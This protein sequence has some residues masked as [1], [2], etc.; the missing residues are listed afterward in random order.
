M[1][2]FIAELSSLIDKSEFERSWQSD[3]AVNPNFK[4]D[5][6]FEGRRV[7]IIIESNLS[8]QWRSE[9]FHRTFTSAIHRVDQHCNIRWL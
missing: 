8:D 5:V 6:G 4:V 7:S 2:R 3:S 1:Q 9:S